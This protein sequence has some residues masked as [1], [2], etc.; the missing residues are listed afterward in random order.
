MI[1]INALSGEEYKRL[2]QRLKVKRYRKR[3]KA[4]AEGKEPNF[5][6]LDEDYIDGYGDEVSSIP[7]PSPIVVSPIKKKHVVTS[8]PQDDEVTPING[9][10]LGGIIAGVIGLVIGL[11]I[12]KA[13]R[14]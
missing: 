3:K 9:W 12:Y 4:V 14:L 7:S 6:I 5:Y 10:V 11:P 1:D 13:K 2:Q 8:I